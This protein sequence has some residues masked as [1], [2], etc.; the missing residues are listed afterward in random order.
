LLAPETNCT[1]DAVHAPTAKD[2]EKLLFNVQ[3]PRSNEA[4]E[5]ALK[6]GS[7]RPHGCLSAGIAR[8]SHTEEAMSEGLMGEK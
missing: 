1:S 3:S 8:L 6:S 7:Q 4:Y 5:R 2:I